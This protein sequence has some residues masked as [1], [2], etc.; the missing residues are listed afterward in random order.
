MLAGLKSTGMQIHAGMCVVDALSVFSVLTFL[1]MTAH[2]IKAFCDDLQSLMSADSQDLPRSNA[3]RRLE[4]PTM[5]IDCPAEPQHQGF[6]LPQLCQGAAPVHLCVREDTGPCIFRL[7]L[8]LQWIRHLQ[9]APVR[10][11][12]EPAALL[13]QP[14][15]QLDLHT[16]ARMPSHACLDV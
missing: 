1:Y 8:D 2:Y 3:R 7:V 12:M 9:R 11:C 14:P 10:R 6:R 13:P 4:A 5:T 15:L 16:A